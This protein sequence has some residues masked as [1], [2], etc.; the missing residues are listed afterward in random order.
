MIRTALIA[1]TAAVVSVG[2]VAPA[3]ADVANEHASCPGLAL[4]DHAVHEGGAAIAGTTAWL[5]ANA[6]DFGFRNSGQIVSRFAK[7]HPGTHI[8]GCEEAIVTILLAGP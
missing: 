1:A 3:T 8:P 2:L 4:S 7:S 5:R 6:E